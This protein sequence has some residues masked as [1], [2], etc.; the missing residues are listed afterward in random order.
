[1]MEIS[2]HGSAN[3]RKSQCVMYLLSSSCMEEM[4]GSGKWR[5]VQVC[6]LECSLDTLSGFGLAL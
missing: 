5:S 4:L 1:M 3:T 6:A 2:G